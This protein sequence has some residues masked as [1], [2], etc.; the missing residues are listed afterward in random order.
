MS[1]SP[2]KGSKR[3]ATFAAKNSSAP[4]HSIDGDQENVRPAKRFSVPWPRAT[5]RRGNVSVNKTARVENGPKVHVDQLECGGDSIRVS[6]T[7]TPPESI[8]VRL[9][10]DG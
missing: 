8:P 5:V 1:A 10:A 2:K 9:S 7:T 6:Y 3:A 4:L